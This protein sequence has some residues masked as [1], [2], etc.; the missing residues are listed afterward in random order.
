MVRHAY[1]H[2]PYIVSLYSTGERVDAKWRVQQGYMVPMLAVKRVAEVVATKVAKAAKYQKC[3]ALW[4]LI[5]VDFWNPAQ[6]QEIEWPQDERIDFGPFERILI[7]K[8][9][10]GQV[11]EVPRFG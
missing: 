1:L 7:Y 9:A 4:L 2:L 5:T 10:Y 8:P 6:D 11:V 3:D